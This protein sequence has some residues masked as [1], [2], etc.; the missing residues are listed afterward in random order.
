[1]VDQGEVCVQIQSQRRK[2]A[3]DAFEA[4]CHTH[5]LSVT[6]Q[7]VA[8]YKELVNS[9][10]HPSAIMVHKQVTAYHP[11]ISLDTVNRT[12]L[13]FREIGLARVVESSGR[14]KRFDA[15]LEPHHHFQCIHCGRIVDF[16][17]R[18]YDSLSL[19]DE[20]AERFLVTEK[21]IH[22]EG[23]CDACRADR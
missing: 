21:I 15:N 13:K 3:L 7:R 5:G 2:A 1:M 16:R 14:S 20:I 12:L 23:I 6:P 11:N 8:I 17:S 4:V 19:P 10:D 18:A 22:L 9:T